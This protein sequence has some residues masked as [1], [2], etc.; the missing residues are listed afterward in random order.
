MSRLQSLRP[1]SKPY[2]VGQIAHPSKELIG[3]L[4]NRP[5]CLF[6]FYVDVNHAPGIE[7]PATVLLWPSQKWTGICR[8]FGQT[9]ALLCFLHGWSPFCRNRSSL[10]PLTHDKTRWESGRRAG[11]TS[12]RTAQNLSSSVNNCPRPESSHSPLANNVWL[13]M[14]IINSPEIQGLIPLT[15]EAAQVSA[16]PSPTLIGSHQLIRLLCTDAF[17]NKRY[18]VMTEEQP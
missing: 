6:L 18:S 14:K 10:F 13:S 5:R 1:C 7:S 2:L 17:F 9:E 3:A 4:R 15:A 8:V 12:L 11:H 16:M